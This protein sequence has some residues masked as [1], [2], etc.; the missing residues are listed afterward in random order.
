MSEIDNQLGDAA[1]V[2]LIGLA[3]ILRDDFKFP[4]WTI[5]I[6]GVLYTLR[7][8]AADNTGKAATAAF[9]TATAVTLVAWAGYEPKPEAAS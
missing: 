1:T 8:I 5:G 4:A 2:I 3:L 6:P 7:W 9:M